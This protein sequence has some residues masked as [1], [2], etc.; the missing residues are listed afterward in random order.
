MNA[1][2]LCI[3]LTFPCGDL[4]GQ[5]VL[6]VPSAMQAWTM[7]EANFRLGHVQPT[8]VFGRV[9]QRDLVQE[10]SRLLRRKRLRQARAIVC[11]QSVLDKTHFLCF[12]IRV[13]HQGSYTASIILA[14]ASGRDVH[15][16]PATQRFTHHAL[17]THAFPLVLIVHPRWRA[18]PR[19]WGGP[20]FP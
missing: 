20:H 5:D 8:A 16:P 11:V 3:A 15:V 12:R 10:A 2:L 4:G 6:V 13:F 9:M 14:S 18:W 1:R 7:H 17:M 19:R